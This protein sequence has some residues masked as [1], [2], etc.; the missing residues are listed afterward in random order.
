MASLDDQRAGEEDVGVG[1]V[2]KLQIPK[3]K[4]QRNAKLQTVARLRMLYS[5][6]KVLDCVRYCAAFLAYAKTSPLLPI[7]P[8]AQ[9]DGEVPGLNRTSVRFR[10]RRSTGAVQNLAEMGALGSA[11]RRDSNC[12][13]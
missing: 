9:D 8:R 10:K 12:S 7:A 5:L 2:R 1:V 4:L 3:S 11:R 13:T 6:R